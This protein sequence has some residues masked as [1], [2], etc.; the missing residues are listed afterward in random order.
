MS[1]FINDPVLSVGV[2][3]VQYVVL[4][5]F[6]IRIDEHVAELSRAGALLILTR[7]VGTIV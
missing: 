5:R 6:R 1:I 7:D 3:V 2:R 4:F